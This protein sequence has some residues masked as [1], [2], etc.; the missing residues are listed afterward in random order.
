MSLQRIETVVLSLCQSGLENESL[1]R[2]LILSKS[3]IVPILSSRYRGR[4]YSRS[5]MLAPIRII[6]IGAGWA[7]LVAAKTYLQVAKSLNRRVE[8]IVLDEG[9]S[10]GGVWSEERIYPG[11]VAETP[12]GFFEY[13]DFSM[14]DVS[15]R[16]LEEFCLP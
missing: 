6:V 5:T 16:F 10:P 9:R 15:P 12:N 3:N 1:R 2:Q 11:L 8:L 14:V 7:G 13:S 4:K